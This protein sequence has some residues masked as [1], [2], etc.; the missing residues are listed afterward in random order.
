MLRSI[1]TAENQLKVMLIYENLYLVA[2]AAIIGIVLGAFL[3]WGCVRLILGVV[4]YFIYSFTPIPFVLETAAFIFI[5]IV[6]AFS[7]YSLNH[8]SIVEA[9]RE[10]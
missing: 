1:G 7:G 8:G 4:D 10:E 5:S 3:S 6:L 9:I 2:I